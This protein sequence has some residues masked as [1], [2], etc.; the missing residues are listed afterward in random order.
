M[1]LPLREGSVPVENSGMR[2]MQIN[3]LCEE[4]EIVFRMHVRWP[5]AK[6]IGYKEVYIC[7][8]GTKQQS[9]HTWTE[10]NGVVYDSYFANRR[11]AD[12]YYG[13]KYD[14][15]EY[16]VVFRQKLPEKYSWL[17]K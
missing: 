17:S 2:S 5:M 7:S 4:E 6:V 9:F 12:K 16:G 8:R 15:F 10:I 1:D 14:D 3:F 13:I 11:D